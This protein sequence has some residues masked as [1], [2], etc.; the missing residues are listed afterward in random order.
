M[1]PSKRV[2]GAASEGAAQQWTR[3][4]YPKCGNHATGL[5]LGNYDPASTSN[6]VLKFS[7]FTSLERLLLPAA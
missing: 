1:K 3:F 2:I 6:A 4:S 5:N 7:P